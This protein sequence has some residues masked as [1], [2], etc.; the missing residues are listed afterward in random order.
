MDREKSKKK[1][2]LIVDT[3]IVVASN[4]Q[5]KIE[6]LMN[7]TLMSTLFA[8]SILR[9]TQ[10]GSKQKKTFTDVT[11]L[12]WKT[13]K[14]LFTG[15]CMRTLFHMKR[16]LH[17]SLPEKQKKKN[18]QQ[19]FIKKHS[20][21][22]LGDV[23]KIR[24]QIVWNLIFVFLNKF[25]NFSKFSSKKNVKKYF[26][27]IFEAGTLNFRPMWLQT[28]FQLS[29]PPSVWRI[30]FGPKSFKIFWIFPSVE[31]AREIAFRQFLGLGR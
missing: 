22:C 15:K 17:K 14:N 1:F 27:P 10:K 19:S 29:I 6:N 20:I 16:K 21:L 9:Y 7:Q 18:T 3:E 2:F 13:W 26:P 4:T 24:P 28:V 12:H 5:H 31:N 30:F 23:G 11:R 8:T 25:S